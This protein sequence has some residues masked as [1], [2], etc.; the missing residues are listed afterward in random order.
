MAEARTDNLT[1][2]FSHTQTQPDPFTGAT[3]ASFAF[4]ATRIIT[5]ITQFQFSRLTPMVRTRVTDI[6]YHI[7]SG[8][9]RVSLSSSSSY[10][11]C[12][13]YFRSF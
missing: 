7:R 4:S 11:E 8:Q 13:K 5:G 1:H 6:G 2:N 9:S 10:N 3:T 12:D